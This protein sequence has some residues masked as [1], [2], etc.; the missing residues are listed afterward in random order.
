MLGVHKKKKGAV[1]GGCGFCC[2]VA[3]GVGWKGAFHILRVSQSRSKIPGLFV[4]GPSLTVARYHSRVLL[5]A[6]L[7]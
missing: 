5:P 1:C 7:P 4:L 6:F 3:R 2:A